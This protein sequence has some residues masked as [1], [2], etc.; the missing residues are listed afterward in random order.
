MWFGFFKDF[1]FSAKI[2]SLKHGACFS[3]IQMY[4]ARYMKKLWDKTLNIYHNTFQAKEHAGIHSLKLHYTCVCVPWVSER[5]REF[6]A[7]KPSQELTQR[8]TKMRGREEKN[9]QKARDKNATLVHYITHTR[10][11]MMLRCNECFPYLHIRGF[12][13]EC[14]VGLPLPYMTS[15]LH[16]KISHSPMFVVSIHSCSL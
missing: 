10:R 16:I 8:D 2:M 12:M 5:S 4:L 11:H 14:T 7:S 15:C 9:G 1:N 13:L 3:K 6:S